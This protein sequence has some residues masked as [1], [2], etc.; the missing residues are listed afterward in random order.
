MPTIS[1]QAITAANWLEALELTVLPDQVAFVPTVALSLAKAYIRPN[2]FCYDPFGLYLNRLTGKQLIGFY[3]LIHLPD[4]V[5][6][7]YLGGFFID[8]RFQRRGYGKAALQHLIHIVQE[9]YP[10][11]EELLLSVHPDNHVAIELYATHGFEK[12]GNWLEDE[13]EMRLGIG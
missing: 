1:T 9:R 6:F 4:D 2:G 13:A 12:T 10:Q 5:T 7:C 3:S 8:Q 11:C